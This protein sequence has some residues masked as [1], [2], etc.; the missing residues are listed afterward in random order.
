MND[1]F[2]V[3]ACLDD[4]GTYE[5]HFLDEPQDAR[6]LPLS[7]CREYEERHKDWPTACESI[8]DYDSIPDVVVTDGDVD[9][10]LCLHSRIIM[11]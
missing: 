10:E 3:D 8:Y 7:W 6:G 2:N 1:E 11:V 4:C 9:W 5:E